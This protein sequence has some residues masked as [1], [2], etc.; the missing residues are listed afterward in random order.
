MSSYHL[1]MRMAIENAK[2]KGND[3]QPL[4]DLQQQWMAEDRERFA[5]NK[6]P[7]WK[8]MWEE[9]TEDIK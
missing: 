7:W 9:I 1:T 8:R 5:R 6:L 3:P 2:L 4:Y